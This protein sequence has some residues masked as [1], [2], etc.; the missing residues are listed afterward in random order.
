MTKNKYNKDKMIGKYVELC[1]RLGRVATKKDINNCDDLPHSNILS[2][3]F[4]SMANLRKAAGIIKNNELPGKPFKEEVERVLMKKR[5]YRGRRL[6]YMEVEVDPDLPPLGYIRR[7]YN[8]KPLGEIWAEVES[9]IPK[10]I[11]DY[12]KI[13]M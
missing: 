3:K 4:G 1:R 11:A 2:H 10:R 7:I 12:L 13:D 5:I 9:K 8:N 6:D